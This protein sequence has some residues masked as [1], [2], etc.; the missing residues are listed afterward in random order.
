ME[1]QELSLL[2]ENHAAYQLTHIRNTS[3]FG[4]ADF[5]PHVFNWQPSAA[6]LD[7][8]TL[9]RIAPDIATLHEALPATEWRFSLQTATPQPLPEKLKGDEIAVTQAQLI[10]AIDQLPQV[11][12]ELQGINAN[13]LHGLIE[14]GLN[15]GKPSQ[16]LR[17]IIYDYSQPQQRLVKSWRLDMVG[18]EKI[19]EA[20]I[21]AAGWTN[22]DRIASTAPQFI[23][24]DH[25][26]AKAFIE[27]TR[28]S[29]GKDHPSTAIYVDQGIAGY[30]PEWNDF[31]LLTHV[32]DPETHVFVVGNS[33]FTYDRATRQLSYTNAHSG[34][35]EPIDVIY[36]F[37]DA[38]RLLTESAIPLLE[39]IADHAVSVE[40]T[41]NPLLNNYHLIRALLFHDDNDGAFR[42][43]FQRAFELAGVSDITNVLERVKE[44][45][46]PMALVDHANKL[47]LSLVGQ[48]GRYYW[49]DIITELRTKEVTNRPK[50]LGRALREKLLLRVL[51]SDDLSKVSGGRGSIKLADIH[52][53]EELAKIF[54]ESAEGIKELRKTG[55]TTKTI[56]GI[57]P[58]IK[59]EP[60]HVRVYGFDDNQEVQSLDIPNATQRCCPSYVRTRA[61]QVPTRCG[62]LSFYSAPD[63]RYRLG[64]QIYALGAHY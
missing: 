1:K 46:I 3:I 50:I 44:Q 20:Q 36:S 34:V 57:E 18:G 45:T 33:G 11:L 29:S 5:P 52:S 48:E 39:A 26:P 47:D 59:H 12:S 8:I 7:E 32:V 24:T 35:Q 28:T 16:L 63:G 62:T 60:R 13:L 10:D 2:P 19:S 58:L 37:A 22:A 43:M 23:G 9:G 17:Q 25:E 21:A 54:T 4:H 15:D 31:R 6:V 56:V 38:R 41:L 55:H 27:M 51:L 49:E 14:Y 40:P 61:G 53:N 42:Q 64:G 30:W